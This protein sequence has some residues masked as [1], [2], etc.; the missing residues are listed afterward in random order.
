MLSH[1]I[2]YLKDYEY[3]FDDELKN[4]IN[5]YKVN[6]VIKVGE[7]EDIIYEWNIIKNLR[8][9]IPNGISKY[10]CS[11]KKYNNKMVILIPFYQYNSIYKSV[12]DN[13]NFIIFKSLIIQVFIHMFLSYHYFG[14]IYR[15]N[16]NIFKKILINETNN[17]TIKHL[18]QSPNESSKRILILKTNGYEAIMTDFEK[19]YYV[20]KKDGIKDYWN[21]IYNF[22]E[23][24][25]SL[26]ITMNNYKIIINFIKNQIDTKSEYDNS[27]KLYYLLSNS[28]YKL[29]SV[30]ENN[31]I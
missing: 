17:E 7:K 6:M 10:I 3:E 22:I 24:I 1:K 28:V 31:F 13:N 16:D 11:P 18:Y 29:N 4:I 23:S 5:P 9:Y 12:W 25:N 15:T 27:I 2:F 8:K 20:H 26:M 14:F 19:S 21:S 30:N